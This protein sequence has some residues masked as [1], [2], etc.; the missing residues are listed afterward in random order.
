LNPEASLQHKRVWISRV[1]GLT[2]QDSIGT[3]VA[4]VRGDVGQ[5]GLDVIA[6]VFAA[7]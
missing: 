5:V 7:S 3:S 2:I 6:A 4:G 1:S